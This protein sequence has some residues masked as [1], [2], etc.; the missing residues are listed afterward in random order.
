MA[1]TLRKWPAVD[2]SAVC[3]VQNVLAGENFVFDGTLRDQFNPNQINFLANGFIRS[4]SIFTA[5]ITAA[6]FTIQ[7]MQNGVHITETINGSPGGVPVFGLKVYDVITSV[8]ADIN[9]DD[10]TIGTGKS[11]FLPLIPVNYKSSLV[12]VMGLNCFLPRLPVSG[13]QY[14]AFSLLEDISNNGEVLVNMV[15]PYGDEPYSNP[16]TSSRIF[17][18]IFYEGADN[19]FAT[20]KA[21]AQVG[22]FSLAI[23]VYIYDSEH[24]ETDTMYVTFLQN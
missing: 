5:A 1:Q 4:I 9:V 23:L 16:D 7:G 14:Q 10:I 19:L 22:L 3:E 11:G 18:S 2:Y 8:T 15:K 20:S 24:P 17:S 13:I 6:V 12:P 21:I